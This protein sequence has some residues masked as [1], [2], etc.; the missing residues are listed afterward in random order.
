MDAEAILHELTYATD[1]PREAL[2]AAS[3]QRVELLPKFLDLIED[4]IGREP[5][6]RGGPTPLF[7]IFRRLGEWREKT[8]YSPLARLLRCP[9]DEADAIFGDAI[10]STSHR[11]MAAVFDGDPQPLC[12]I[13]LAPNPE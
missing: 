4:Y 10:P 8:A 3:A 12:E 11:V 7:F 9:A 13:I 6:A 5:D 2:H 1:L